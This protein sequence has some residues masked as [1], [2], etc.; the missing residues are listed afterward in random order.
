VACRVGNVRT[1]TLLLVKVMQTAI[2]HKTSELKAEIEATHAHLSPVQR[3]QVLVEMAARYEKDVD[4][5]QYLCAQD[6]LG[7]NPVH[8]AAMY[9]H[10]VI[11]EVYCLLSSSFVLLSFVSFVLLSFVFVFG[12]VFVF[13]FCHRLL[14]LYLSFV[15]V[16]VFCLYRRLLSLSLSRLC[17]N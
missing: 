6:A 14:S 13:C 2:R 12:Y 17:W 3:D 15:F 1:T 4:Y 11:L 10:L 5:S 8:V 9:G 16:I 7:R